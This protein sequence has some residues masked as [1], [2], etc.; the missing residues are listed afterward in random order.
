MGSGTWIPIAIGTWIAGTAVFMFLLH[1]AFVMPLRRRL[2]WLSRFLIGVGGL[3]LVASLP[4]ALAWGHLYFRGVPV[5]A[6]VVS[7]VQGPAHDPD[8]DD[9]YQRFPV[10]HVTYRFEADVGGQ[11][12]QF[13]REGELAGRYRAGSGFVRVLYDPADPGNSRMVREFGWTRAVLLVAA[14]LLALGVGLILVLRRGRRGGAG[15]VSA[16]P[17]PPAAASL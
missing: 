14:A 4:A 12:R 1:P 2:V 6:E 9:G 7:M 16:A 15:D 3:I 13:R 5:R 8:D 17:G 10:T 11:P